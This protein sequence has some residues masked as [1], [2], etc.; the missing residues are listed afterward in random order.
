MR[1]V[2]GRRAAYQP[3]RSPL[4]PDA[5][6]LTLA[7][8]IRER[9]DVSGI[10][11]ADLDALAQGGPTAPEA[12][13]ALWAALAADG[14]KLL[15]DPGVRRRGD[16][17]A[18]LTPADSRVVVATESVESLDELRASLSIPRTVL[19]YDL[20]AGVPVGPPGVAALLASVRSPALAL[21]MAAVGLFGGV[22]TLPLCRELIAANPARLVATGG[23][24]RSINDV[25]AAAAAGVSELLVASA[26]YD[27]RLSDDDL[28]PY[29]DSIA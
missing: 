3:F 12:N 24:V 1:A 14:F 27:G 9:W 15:L 10:Y 28:R 5:D 11:V 29:L 2:A 23:G 21:D 6:P 13:V 8:R 4:S 16:L 19:G 7:R 18:G 26:L 20:R 22:A 17:V 25:R